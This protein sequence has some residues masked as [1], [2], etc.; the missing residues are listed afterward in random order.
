MTEFEKAGGTYWKEEKYLL[1]NLTL[2]EG[3]Q[4]VDI[5]VW[6]IR[7]RRYLKQH[8]RVLYYNLLPEGKLDS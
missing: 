3:G 2:P 7:H 6:G 4:A 1:P 8:H 5:G